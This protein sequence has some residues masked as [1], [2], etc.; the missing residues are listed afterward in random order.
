M[1]IPYLFIS[2]SSA[3]TSVLEAYSK[4]VQGFFEKQS[5]YSELEKSIGIIME[6]WKRSVTPTPMNIYLRKGVFGCINHLGYSINPVFD[7]GGN[8]HFFINV[9]NA[10][11]TNCFLG[12]EFMILISCAN[13]DSSFKKARRSLI[14]FF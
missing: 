10:E 7:L 13:V 9:L 14:L 2:T 5:S 11:K 12:A 6:Y 4:P 1:C 8:L 3:L